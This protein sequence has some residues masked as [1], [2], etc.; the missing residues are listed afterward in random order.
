MMRAR[1]RI[2]ACD[3]AEIV[4]QRGPALSTPLSLSRACRRALLPLSAQ[5]RRCTLYAGAVC[6]DCDR[7]L[8]YYHRPPSTM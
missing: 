7:L 2:S 1:D 5:S 6:S 3:N 8:N 4:P